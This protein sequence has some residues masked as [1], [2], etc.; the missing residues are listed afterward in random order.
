MRHKW[1]L[2]QYTLCWGEIEGIQLVIKLKYISEHVK[3][4]PPGV[5]TNLYV[6]V[7]YLVSVVGECTLLLHV[8]PVI[9]HSHSFLSSLQLSSAPVWCVMH[10]YNYNASGCSGLGSQTL[11]LTLSNITWPIMTCI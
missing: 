1:G 10:N 8:M 9:I 5:Y 2:M 6:K 11:F 3:K 7:R 4:E